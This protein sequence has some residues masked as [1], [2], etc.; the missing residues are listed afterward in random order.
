MATER[1]RWRPS[2]ADGCRAPQMAAL[3][4]R[5]L[6]STADGCQAP[7]KAAERFRWRPSSR[8]TVAQRRRW[9]RLAA[10]CCAGPPSTK[11]AH[12]SGLYSIGKIICRDS[13][14]RSLRLYQRYNRA[15]S[16]RPQ[17]A[18]G[19]TN[20]FFFSGNFSFLSASYMEI[21]ASYIKI[22]DSIRSHSPSDQTHRARIVF[23]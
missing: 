12:N 8:A 6:P 3:L 2:S 21:S 9:Q 7:P 5:R 13:D 4:S 11:E 1:R 23:L 20:P 19:T 17:P 22:S 10:I 16:N 15:D 18:R 14:L